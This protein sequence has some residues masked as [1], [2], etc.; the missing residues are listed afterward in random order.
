MRLAKY[1]AQAGI[2]SR[3]KA[4]ELIRQGK[5]KLNGLTVTD[6]TTPVEPQ[7]DRVEVDDRLVEGE[8]P[9]YIL[10]YKP[11]GF[12]CSVHDPQKRSTVLDLV[13]TAGQRVYPVGRLDYDTEGLLLLTNDGPFTNLMIHPRYKI[14]KKYEAGIK[15]YIEDKE[16]D[17]LRNGVDL[18]DGLTAPAGVRLIKRDKRLSII[19]LTIHEGRKRQ[20][21][22][23][24]RAVGHPV[25]S[26]KRTALGFLTLQGLEKG[27][28]RH[29]ER[30]EI[31]RL[32]ALALY[33]TP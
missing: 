32:Q 19:E 10:L 14:A 11:A 16:L 21:K 12:I 9:V 15:G 22:R 1:L 27:E 31:D 2:A 26:L 5:V 33:E 28:Y 8:E 20:V 23:M 30:D 25:I 18:E 4:E 17:I 7:N 3:R 24:C 13:R 6:V 29:L